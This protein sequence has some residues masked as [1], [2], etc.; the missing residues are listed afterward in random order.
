[1]LIAFMI[2]GLKFYFVRSFIRMFDHLLNFDLD[3]KDE[4]DSYFIIKHTA[5][6]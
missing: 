5:P 2:C 4:L 3:R 1:M 6:N